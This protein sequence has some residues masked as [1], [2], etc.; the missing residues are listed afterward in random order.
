LTG[1][2]KKIDQRLEA[3]HVNSPR[4]PG[5]FVIVEN[6]ADGIDRYLRGM[7]GNDGLKRASLCIGAPPEDYNLAREAEVTVVIYNVGRR[8]QQKVTANFAL[9][10]GELDEAKTEAIIKAL[11][12]VLPKK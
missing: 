2:V 3:T 9:R 8:G 6:E 11:S 7:A 10:K 5:V 1:L 12:D 4:P